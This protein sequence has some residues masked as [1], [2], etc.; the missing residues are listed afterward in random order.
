MVE[1]LKTSVGHYLSFSLSPLHQAMVLSSEIEEVLTV[2][3]SKILSIFDLPA[4]VMGAYN[5]RGEILWF[6]DLPKFLGLET[7]YEQHFRGQFSILLL[8]EGDQ[9]VGVGINQIGPLS[10]GYIEPLSSDIASN[11][12]IEMAACVNGVMS[13]QTGQPLYALS[14]RKIFQQIKA[15]QTV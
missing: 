3:P 7:L 5:Y 11:L 15:L 1:L 2:H 10:S 14:R 9:K 8:E 6:I 13:N 4:H 12:P